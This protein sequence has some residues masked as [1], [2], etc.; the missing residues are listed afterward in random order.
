MT[1]VEALERVIHC[2]DRSFEDGHRTKSFVRALDTVRRVEPAELLQR[3]A[4]STLTE[5][6]GVGHD[7]WT[8]AYNDPKGALPWMF[9]QHR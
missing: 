1:P 5:L 8:A 7:S 3:A 9:Q 6:P 2:L 4:N